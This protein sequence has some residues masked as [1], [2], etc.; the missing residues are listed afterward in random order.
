MKKAKLGDRARAFIDDYTRDLTAR[1]LQRVFTRD[2]RAMVSFFTQGTEQERAEIA[3]RMLDRARVVFP[4]ARDVTVVEYR[5]GVRP[6]PADG[7]TIAGRIPGFANA[8]MIATHSGVTLG[9]L[10]GAL[11]ADEI[12]RD[13]PTPMLAP[14]RPDRFTVSRAPVED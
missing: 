13:T 12:I 6:V 9:A 10:L 2:T 1:D 3:S 8:W 7:H 4:A 14:F 5:V 11:V